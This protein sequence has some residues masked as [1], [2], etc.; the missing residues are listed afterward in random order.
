MN[1]R[2]PIVP[3]A[4]AAQDTVEDGSIHLYIFPFGKE[5]SVSK[6]SYRLPGYTKK[7]NKNNKAITYQNYTQNFSRAIQFC[8]VFATRLSKLDK[9]CDMV[10]GCD[11]NILS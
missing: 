5:S 1:I 10:L 7:S 9:W 6:A 2:D 11:Q 8:L 4:P 3:L